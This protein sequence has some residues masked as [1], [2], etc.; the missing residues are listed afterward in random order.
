MWERRLSVYAVFSGRKTAGGCGKWVLGIPECS[1]IGPM[2]FIILRYDL[3]SVRSREVRLFAN[4][5][6]L[7]NSS[8]QRGAASILQKGFNRCKQWSDDWLLRFHP[9]KSTGC[10]A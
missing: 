7:F 6:K 1:V 5:T 4:D 3:P 2:L 9:E 10:V 8:D